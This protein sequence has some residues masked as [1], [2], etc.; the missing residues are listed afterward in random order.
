MYKKLKNITFILNLK[1]KKELVLLNS[2][3]TSYM[4]LVTIMVDWVEDITQPTPK[5]TVNGLTLMIVQSDNAHKAVFVDL[6]HI[7]YFIRGKTD[8]EKSNKSPMKIS[9]IQ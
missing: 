3:S 7:S 2:P 1:L 4:Q 5:T 8:N 6:E 9:K